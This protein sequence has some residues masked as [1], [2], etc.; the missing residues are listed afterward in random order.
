MRCYAKPWHACLHEC[1]RI[2][3][4][5][6]AFTYDAR[7]YVRMSRIYTR[8]ICMRPWVCILRCVIYDIRYMIYDIDNTLYDIHYTIYG[9]RYTK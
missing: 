9:I 7:R 5:T 1:T 4:V 8:G 3:H 2:V 6:G